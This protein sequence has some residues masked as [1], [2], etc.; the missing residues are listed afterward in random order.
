MIQIKRENLDEIALW[1]F[2]ELNPKKNKGKEYKAGSLTKLLEK[3]IEGN[4][5]KSRIG[6]LFLY[7]SQDN[8]GKTNLEDIITS[9]PDKLQR[10]IIEIKKIFKTKFT[11]SELKEI[12]KLFFYSQY[13]KWHPYELAE[14]LQVNVCPYCNRQYTFTANKKNCKKG[15]RP[16]FDHFLPR[17]K[18]PYLALSFY[19]L[20]PSC[21]TCNHIKGDNDI[22]FLH[23]YLNGFG[24]DV[25]FILEPK[26]E[27]DKIPV[28]FLL[29]DKNAFNINFK[30]KKFFRPKK[31]AQTNINELRLKDLYNGHKDYV[32]EIIQKAIAY[33]QS[34]VDDLFEKYEGKLF[35]SK[36]EIIR[37][38][39][40]NYINED[41]LDKRVLAKLTKDISDEYQIHLSE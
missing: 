16:E 17:S 11:N 22:Q 3:G 1:H 28:S 5:K 34:Y 31:E 25:K 9:N 39:W 35:S 2:K 23:P 13:S 33:D 4:S 10:H 19:N 27:E 14:K 7:L 26:K 30:F 41:E 40:G 6:K 20:I 37:M 32:Q 36:D 38:Y 15:T 21:H 29:G 24:D 18:Y 12:N 8:N